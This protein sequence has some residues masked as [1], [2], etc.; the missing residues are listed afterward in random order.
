MEKDDRSSI[1][2]CEGVYGSISIK[3]AVNHVFKRE[4]RL[5]SLQRNFI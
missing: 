1:S 2:H 5:P 3:D 4:Y